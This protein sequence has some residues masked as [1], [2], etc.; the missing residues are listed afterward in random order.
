M[1]F[2]LFRDCG[3]CVLQFL[4]PQQNRCADAVGDQAAVAR[5][6]AFQQWTQHFHQFFPAETLN[7]KLPAVKCLGCVHLSV[8]R[9]TKRPSPQVANERLRCNVHG[10]KLRIGQQPCALIKKRAVVISTIL[11]NHSNVIEM[12]VIV[13]L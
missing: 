1:L 3:L 13:L 6:V 11:L 9:R 10:R 4:L 12:S 7:L 5:R 8:E 2:R